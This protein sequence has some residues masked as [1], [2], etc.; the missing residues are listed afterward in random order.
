MSKCAVKRGFVALRD[1]GNQASDTCSVCARPVCQEHMKIQATN[2]FCVEC[3]ARQA[4][5]DAAAKDATGFKALGKTS[6]G[7]A[8]GVKGGGGARSRPS[9]EEALNDPAY[10]YYYRD[11]YYSTYHYS[12]FWYSGYH[13]H[14]YDSYDV[15]SFD[16]TGRDPS[17]DDDSAADG[18][19]DS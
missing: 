7:G 13:D 4:S 19:Y 11:H 16:N 17:V 2:I 8:K 12:P 5:A 10:P 6:G 1:C 18:F 14:Y 3:Y 15:R 9:E